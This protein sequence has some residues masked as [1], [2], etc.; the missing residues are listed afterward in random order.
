MPT[1]HPSNSLYIRV[2]ECCGILWFFFL[3]QHLSIWHTDRKIESKKQGTDLSLSWVS[4]CCLC[5]MAALLITHCHHIR[6]LKKFQ[7][8]DTNYH[9][10]KPLP[11]ARDHLWLNYLLKENMSVSPSLKRS[12]CLSRAL[13]YRPTVLP[14][15]I[16]LHCLCTDLVR[17][18]ETRGHFSNWCL[19]GM[20]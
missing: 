16:A 19:C 18:F 10:V 8:P 20:W 7:F 11:F 2:F 1:Y 6:L 9:N 5:R 4:S 3:A 13:F 14:S 12:T 17:Q 15:L